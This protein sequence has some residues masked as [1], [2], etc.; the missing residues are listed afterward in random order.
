[1]SLKDR[2]SGDLKDAMRAKDQLRLDTLRS[3]ISAFSYRK[4]EAGREL[5]DDEQVDVVRKLVKQRS[6]SIS[7]F[8]KAGRT[9]L[10]EKETR[11]RDILAALLP[12]QKT[13]EDIRPAVRAALA[14]LAPEQRNQGA[15][16][17]L[18]MP[19]LRGETDGGT[20]RAVVVEELRASEAAPP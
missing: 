18:L 19:A 3:A 11:E 9:D 7:E 2:I 6:D 17:K 20:I 8:G 13:A 5:G 10:V 12:A 4:I 1:M 16:M 14:S 15:A